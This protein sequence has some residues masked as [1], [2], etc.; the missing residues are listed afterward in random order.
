MKKIRKSRCWRRQSDKILLILLLLGFMVFTGCERPL[1]PGETY[2]K[3]SSAWPL[4][5]LEKSEG[6]EPD[7]SKWQKEKGDA[8]CWLQT[9]EKEKRYDKDGFFVLEGLL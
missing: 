8:C 6:I 5:D 7:G 1:P 9:W 3:V 4:F 2:H